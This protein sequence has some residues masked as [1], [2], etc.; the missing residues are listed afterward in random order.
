MMDINNEL[1]TVEI[2]EE[3]LCT[4]SSVAAG[5]V[6][7]VAGLSATLGNN[8]KDLL[9][10]KY[11]GKGIGIEFVDEGLVIT[12]NIVVK[13]KYNVQDVAVKVQDAIL[14]AISDMTNYEVSAVNVNVVN[15]QISA[16]A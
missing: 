1:G 14:S 4:I 7:G 2:S 11:A 15:I 10:K 13:Y 8:I 3:V 12:A 5:E 6:D 9:T 16:E